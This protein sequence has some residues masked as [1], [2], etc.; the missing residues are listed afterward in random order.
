MAWILVAVP[1]LVA[2]LVVAAGG[3][4]T[5][6]DSLFG[7]QGALAAEQ[8]RDEPCGGQESKGYGEVGRE[9]PGE[10][11]NLYL[12]QTPCLAH[13]NLALQYRGIVFCEQ[14]CRR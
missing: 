7:R 13:G 5:Y 10:E 12:Y 9:D 4:G 11:S 14:S 1:V 2:A 8:C 6:G 3:R